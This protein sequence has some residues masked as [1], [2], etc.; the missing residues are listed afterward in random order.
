MG[1]WSWEGILL[2]VAVFLFVFGLILTQ[3]NVSNPFTGHETSVIS[4]IISW[5][6]H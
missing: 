4:L 2:I 5:I 3:I 1:N 6:A